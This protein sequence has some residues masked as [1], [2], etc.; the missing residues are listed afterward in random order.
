MANKTMKA[1]LQEIETEKDT[2]LVPEIIKKGVTIFGIEGTY[3]GESAG[4]KTIGIRVDFENNTIERIGTTT[5]V[6]DLK[7]Y[8]DRTRCNLQDDGT[9]TAYYGD[10][11][12]D[13]IGNEN[14]QV[15]VE[16]PSVYYS[17]QNVTVGSENEILKAD[18]LVSDGPQEGFE[19]HPAFVKGNKTYGRLYVGAYEGTL[20]NDKL[21]SIGG[22]TSTPSVNKTRAQF[23]TYASNR[24]AGYQ[25]LSVAIN[26]LEKLMMAI[27]YQS[28]DFQSSVAKGV[29]DSSAAE[30]VGQ[31]Y[32][33]DRNGTGILGGDKTAS[34]S[35]TWRFR[36]NPYGNV[37]KFND[38]LNIDSRVWYYS[39]TNFADDDFTNYSRIGTAGS[40]DGYITRFL[41]GDNKALFIPKVAGNNGLIQDYYY[42]STL[43]AILLTGGGWDDG[44]IAGGFRVN[45]NSKA[46]RAT[47][48]M[49]GVL[50]YY[51]TDGDDDEF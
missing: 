30:A 13:N 36:E 45:A 9:I 21:S 1:K 31:T 26:D 4:N 17:L 34:K 35:F 5:N 18:Y 46:S 44:A 24:G 8:K 10:E 49:G 41:A 14:L 16:Q 2:N 3:E 37:W 20:V 29:T 6:N 25:Q 19:L 33:L 22:G 39:N 12:Y 48:Y 27:E 50:A 43:K 38:G 32:T 42:P 7:L 51:S 15:M 11:N 23:R 28:F 40:S 47:G